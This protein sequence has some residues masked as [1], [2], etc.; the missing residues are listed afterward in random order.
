MKRD[1]ARIE[2]DKKLERLE[3]KIINYYRTAEKE[4]RKK[5]DAYM[6][7]VDE[8]VHDFLVELQ[9]AREHGDDD[10]IEKALKDYKNAVWE[11]TIT[12]K[13]YRDMVEEVTRQISSANETALS[14]INGEVPEIYAINLNWNNEN[15]QSF[16]SGYSFTLMDKDT[17]RLLL[18]GDESYMD[19]FKQIDIPKDQRW[20]K[21]LI[22]SQVTQ[23]ILQGESIDKIS[24]RFR[25]VTNADMN[26]AIRNAR[27]MTTG[28]ENRGRMDS[29]ARAK[30]QGIVLKKVW[31][32]ALDERTREWHAEID[33]DEKDQDEPFENSKGEIMFPGDPS[34]HPANIYNCR[35]SLGS[36]VIGF[37]RKDGSI[38]YV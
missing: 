5:W 38:S 21:K 25:N 24:D 17:A 10:L 16:V 27:T 26:A 33:G 9:R 2:T 37:R 8:Q 4:L 18:T 22:H 20:N 14:Y 32:A 30:E 19:Y 7:E 3:K 35:C 28:I 12:S 13:R 31:I 1:P 15:I 23:G 36:R 11:R 34:A 29:Y 6:E